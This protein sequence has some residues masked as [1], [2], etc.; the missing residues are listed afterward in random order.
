MLIEKGAD[1]NKKEPCNGQ[2][3]LIVA[4]LKGH[5]EA[6]LCLDDHGSDINAKDKMG[7]NPM[8][9]DPLDYLPWS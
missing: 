5:G 9:M 3:A 4:A 1:V 8:T 6:A 7:F 2:A